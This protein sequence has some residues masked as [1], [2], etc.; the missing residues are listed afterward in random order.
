MSVQNAYSFGSHIGRIHNFC[1]FTVLRGFQNTPKNYGR[2]PSSQGLAFNIVNICA[3]FPSHPFTF[4]QSFSLSQLK[5]V[6]TEHVSSG[7]SFDNFSCPTP[8]MY[9]VRYIQFHL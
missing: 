8:Y 7:N 9:M 1:I 5:I 3:G 4:L 6:D 2:V